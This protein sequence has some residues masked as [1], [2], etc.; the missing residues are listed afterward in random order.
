VDIRVRPRKTLDGAPET[1]LKNRAALLNRREIFVTDFLGLKRL[2][3]L[4]RNSFLRVID[5]IDVRNLLTHNNSPA[6]ARPW[7]LEKANSPMNGDF[8]V[9]T[10][11]VQPKLCRVSSDGRSVHVRAKVMDLLVFMARHPN[12]VI[13]KDALLNGVW[14]TEAVSESALT[15]SMTELR[16]ALGDPV[17]RPSVIETISKRGYR[18]IAPVSAIEY[19]RPTR[20]ES[21]GIVGTLDKNGS[22]DQRSRI[23]HERGDALLAPAGVLRSRAVTRGR[24]LVIA[25][26]VVV[27]VLGSAAFLRRSPP[28]L[29]FGARDWLLVTE[30]RNATGE[31]VLDGTIQYAFERELS[32][33]PYLSVV[34]LDRVEDA[35]RLM[36]KP[37]D[38]PIDVG[39][40]REICARDGA[41]RALIVGRI[42]KIGDRYSL[43]A[44][45]VNPSNGVPVA[46]FAD[47]V[48]GPEPLLEAVRREAFAVRQALG[49]QRES[50]S[51]SQAQLAKVT[52]PSLRALRLYS[53]A[54]ALMPDNPR[55]A[56]RYLRDA[57]RED[58][59][60]ASAHI[61]LAYSI[62][63]SGGPSSEYLQHAGEAL[64][65]SETTTAVERHF[66]AGSVHRLRALAAED[67]SKAQADL[68]EAI[69]EYEAVLG[70]QPDH[71]W[72][73][74]NIMHA[75]S[76][77]GWK[78]ELAAVWGRLARQRPNDFST[79]VSAARASL[80]ASGLE[81]AR[82]YIARAQV[83]L[84]V[85]P[86]QT[87]Y[88]AIQ[89]S[90]VLMF[91]AHELWVQRRVKEASALLDTISTR[92]ELE[93][94]G[95]WAF[96]LLGSFQVSLGQLKR[97]EQTFARMQDGD[98][99]ATAFGILAL[100]RDDTM[101]I[102]N[103]LG[104]FHG[105]DLAAVSLLVRAG[106]LAAA[107]RVLRSVVSAPV[108]HT[109]WAAAEIEEARGNQSVVHQAV[110]AGT[111]WAHHMKGVRAYL[112]SETLARAAAKAGDTA[113]A[114]RVLEETA[115]LKDITYPVIDHTGYLW[116]RTQL[117]L[118]DLYRTAGRIDEARAIERDLTAALAAADDDAPMLRQVRERATH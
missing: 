2:D 5:S 58:P 105:Q 59:N 107:E 72:S 61:L 82:P 21:S 69:A 80:E 66:I 35:L 31:S 94:D 50:L 79:N 81:A 49:E 14:G 30:F 24:A 29:A 64:R 26:A 99:R 60:F 118:A 51:A 25:G 34:S 96:M 114:I 9:G 104:S 67:P 91:P 16:Q 11:L 117:L 6:A 89:K 47:V 19:E 40:G 108:E 56:E 8:R 28:P 70:L 116:M 83:L 93:A 36:G 102:V 98:K 57:L 48:Q 86:S 111:P 97:A 37:T 7:L 44:Q 85:L 74:I 18:L 41:I 106:D 115:A 45:I 53:Q 4:T 55:P 10:W 90:Y 42:D 3:F 22:V 71:A 65:L 68:V 27:A 33:S 112:Y 12:E 17:D 23:P 54:A 15:R 52:T 63:N 43:A 109:R 77:L 76:S 87:V 78:V 103:A 95:D 20:I 75:Y 110:I 39:I 32:S 46:S 62:K 113:G 1:R 73:I 101:A 92:S 88:P 84:N 13:S 38:T 100:A